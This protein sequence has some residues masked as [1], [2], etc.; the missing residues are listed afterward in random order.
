MSE[1]T[2]PVANI[3]QARGWDGPDGDNWTDHE[4]VYNAAV[5]SL[6][7]ILMEAAEIAPDARV[8]DIGCGCG[9]TTRLAARAARTGSALGV[10]LSTRMIARARER[11]A[12][13]DLPNARF[14]RGDAQVYPFDVGAFDAAISRF[15]GTFFSDP[16]DAYRNIGRA[17]ASGGELTMLCWRELRRN[18]WVT[19][20]REA[21]AAGRD[22]P[23]P[24]P[25]VPSPFLFADPD[26]A[27]T[28][29]HGAGFSDITFE[30]MDEP[31]FFGTDAAVANDAIS[32]LGI[33]VGLLKDLDQPTRA[34]A[35]DALGAAI[36]DHETSDGV[37][38]ASSAWVV[39]ATNAR[40]GKGES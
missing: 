6:T 32:E 17:L 19:A 9:E 40:G 33:V 28:I 12:A 37:L 13:E 3:D 26:R 31:L 20:I 15:G 16:I 18:E 7:P 36:S 10:D 22:L 14:E 39:R 35:L 21:L 25:D 8:I 5:R 4:E 23:E 38:F 11:A 2:A 27:R 34:H 29:L 30:P 24:P 1:A